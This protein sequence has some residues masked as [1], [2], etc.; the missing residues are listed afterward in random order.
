MKT[1]QQQK[2]RKK[3][4]QAKKKTTRKQK[5]KTARIHPDTKNNCNRLG[6]LE[7]LAVS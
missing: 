5:Q 3:N 7:L 4:K 6:A 2:H 1:I